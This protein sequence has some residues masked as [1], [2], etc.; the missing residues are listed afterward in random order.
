MISVVGTSGSGKT[1]TIEYLT[2]HLTKLG[3]TV[4][5][6]KHIHKEGFTVDSEGKDT[7]RHAKAGARVVIA[8]SPNELAVIT[9]TPFESKFEDV[10]RTLRA[11][12]LDIALLEGFSKALANRAIRSKI[13]TAK[14][15]HDL[16]YTLAKTPAPIM[17]ITGPV[18]RGSRSKIRN[19]PAPILDI[20][21]EGPILLSIVR[22]LLR[23]EDLKHL[24]HQ[25]S[26]HH[27]GTCVGLAIGLRAAY[28]AS[29]AFGQNPPIPS[30]INCGTRY[31][32]GSAFRTVFPR[33]QVRFERIKNDTIMVRRGGE[34]LVIHLTPRR[35]FHGP[36]QVLTAPEEELF[37]SV[38]LSDDRPGG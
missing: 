33:S 27:E 7:W 21:R 38:S 13:V 17:A 5:V 14:N 37:E 20:P 34:K 30:V 12:G 16:E 25:A 32:I 11:Q 1:A 23:P 15:A 18:A 29:S 6:G 28:L 2:K 10:A 24:L 26:L 36:L 8:V 3:F 22:R 35:K 9:R 4:G 19:A 31:C